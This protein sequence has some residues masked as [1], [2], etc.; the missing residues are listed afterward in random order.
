MSGHFGVAP[1]PFAIAIR[2]SPA[3]R[4]S[5]IGSFCIAGCTIERTPRAGS[6]SSSDSSEWS[7]GKTRSQASAVS[8]IEVTIAILNGTFSI[9][10][11]K[12]AQPGTL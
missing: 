8:S 4:V 2:T 10:A 11:G 12:P 3:A 1:A 6:T 7:T 9:A 5:N